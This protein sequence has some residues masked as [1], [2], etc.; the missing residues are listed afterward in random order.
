MASV[1]VT[2][3][4]ASSGSMVSSR[5]I[6]T[7]AV[8]K[9]GVNWT[10]AHSGSSA[11]RRMMFSS[12]LRLGGGCAQLA[13]EIDGCCRN[14]IRC[15]QWGIFARNRMAIE[16]PGGLLEMDAAAS[17]NGCLIGEPGQVVL[18]SPII[19]W[20]QCSELRR[21]AHTFVVQP[22]GPTA[23]NAK[24]RGIRGNFRTSLQRAEFGRSRRGGGWAYA[25]FR[26]EWLGFSIPGSGKY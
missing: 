6:S 16:C 10:H 3:A 7:L 24:F 5:D 26:H 22:T 12:S 23:T 1:D 8:V 17:R 18:A 19:L 11:P 20:P 15:R 21:L 9:R 14:G 13:V 2:I 25:R 4:A